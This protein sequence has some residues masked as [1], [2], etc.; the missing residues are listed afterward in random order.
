MNDG[1][2]IQTIQGLQ[3]ENGNELVQRVILPN[4]KQFPRKIYS[5]YTKEE[6][7]EIIGCCRNIKDMIDTMKINNYYHTYIVNFINNNNN[8]NIDTSHFIREKSV[9]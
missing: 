5:E 4:G 1:S 2:E 7:I 9:L 8:N 3:E 6:L